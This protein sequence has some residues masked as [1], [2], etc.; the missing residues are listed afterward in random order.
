MRKSMLAIVAIAAVVLAAN[1]SAQTCAMPPSGMVGW[2][3]GDGNASDIAGTNNGTLQGDA[4][5]GAG[6]VGQAFSFDGDG[7]YV[8]VPDDA[9]LD[10]TT[11]VT[12]DGWVYRAANGRMAV[13]GKRLVSNNTGYGLRVDRASDG[14]DGRVVGTVYGQ[15]DHFSTGTVPAGVW[16]H[17]AWTYDRNA[18]VSRVYINGSF[19]SQSN[20]T[21]AINT[22]DAELW[23]GRLDTSRSGG[24]EWSA[25]LVDEVEVFNRALSETEIQAIYN[26]GSLG[27][28]KPPQ[29]NIKPGSDPNSINTCSQGATPVTIWGSET[30][31][32]SKIDQD[33]LLFA[34]AAVKTVGRSGRSLCSIK[35]VGSYDA[36]FPDNLNPTPDGYDDLTCHFVTFNLALDDSSTQAAVTITGCDDPTVTGDPGHCDTGDPG[37]FE[38][39]SATDSVN[40][41]KD[42]E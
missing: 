3:P 4:T 22:N 37:Y 17:V 33:Q 7:D 6:E 34:S 11:A 23:I 10:L 39:V 41:V 42:C 19:D 9:S 38:V 18:A 2:W 16:T 30:L 24:P 36:S 12:I 29:I 15:F 14:P 40:I 1:A 5:F 20:R 32:V 25:G 21:N 26:A 8:A 27:K 13:A 35:D 28:C 31:D